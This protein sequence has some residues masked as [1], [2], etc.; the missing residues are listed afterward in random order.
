MFAWQ[1]CDSLINSESSEAIHGCLQ[2]LAFF[3]SARNWPWTLS[4]AG[5]VMIPFLFETSYPF[6]SKM[7]FEEGMGEGLKKCPKSRRL[8]FTNGVICTLHVRGIVSCRSFYFCLFQRLP[9]QHG[10][11]R[12]SQWSLEMNLA[13]VSFYL[14]I[15]FTLSLFF[16]PYIFPQQL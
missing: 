3:Y 6:A 14:H 7:S 12:M 11:R 4:L 10:R 8:E 15:L 2:G 13:E 5:K 16:L 9:G 1:G